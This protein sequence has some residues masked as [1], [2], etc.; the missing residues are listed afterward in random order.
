MKGQVL[1]AWELGLGG[2]DQQSHLP[3]HRPFSSQWPHIHLQQSLEDEIAK[4]EILIL[5][6]SLDPLAIS[7]A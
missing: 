6:Q 5:R 7:E 3:C 1:H 4:E 2:A